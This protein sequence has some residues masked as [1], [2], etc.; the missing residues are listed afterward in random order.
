MYRCLYGHPNIA[1]RKNVWEILL[2]FGTSRKES[3][4]MLGDFNE[5]LSN[6]EKLGG[7]RRSEASFQDFSDML[8]GCGMIELSSSGN[9]FTWGG[10]RNN[11]WIQSKLDR[12]FGN[13]E[14]FRAFPAS[15]QR[16]LEK[17]GSD[18]RPVL[19]NLVSSQEAYRGSFRFDKRLLH[20]PQVREAVVKAWNCPDQSFGWTVSDRIRS[21]RKSLS[22]WKKEHNF[23]S[24]DSRAFL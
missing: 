6:D 16:F 8:K 20:Q 12:S 19:I 4:L 10:K 22:K 1:E 11:V 2:R 24:K 21:C 17:R 18:H 15:N 7:P 23:N 9:S 3:W 5:I 14:R 13:K